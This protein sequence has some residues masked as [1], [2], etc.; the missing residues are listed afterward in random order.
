MNDSLQLEGGVITE[1]LVDARNRLVEFLGL[2][3]TAAEACSIP[4]ST[5]FAI[6]DEARQPIQTRCV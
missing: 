2:L 3:I 5:F 4:T 1:K 6:R